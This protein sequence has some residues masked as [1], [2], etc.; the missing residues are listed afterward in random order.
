MVFLI[1]GLLLRELFDTLTSIASCNFKFSMMI[2][3]HKQIKV[4]CE[5]SILL[6]FLAKN[7]IKL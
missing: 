5:F 4:T 7:N 3:Y 2:K 1:K 6:Q